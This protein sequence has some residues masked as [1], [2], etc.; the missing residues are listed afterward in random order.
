MENL[1]F[2]EL[3]IEEMELVD[4]GGLFKCLAGIVGGV[5]CGL[6]A[7]VTSPLA[8]FGCEKPAATCIEAMVACAKWAES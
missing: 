6:G 3:T 2:E 5:G 7:L 1:M 4:G 8:F